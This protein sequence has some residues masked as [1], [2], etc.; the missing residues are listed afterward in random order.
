MSTPN[1]DEITFLVLVT[2][3]GFDNAWYTYKGI[4]GAVLYADVCIPL[5]LGLNLDACA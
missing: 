4:C 2:D 3:S 1:K 5:V